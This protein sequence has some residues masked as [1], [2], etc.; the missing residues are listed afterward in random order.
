MLLSIPGATSRLALTR[1]IRLSDPGCSS[2]AVCA[3]VGNCR[4]GRADVPE[5]RKP[6]GG[7]PVDVVKRID[8]L[9]SAD[10]RSPVAAVAPPRKLVDKAES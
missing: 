10:L 3:G 2:E 6:I 9:C 4:G 8:K 5:S 7:R 1:S